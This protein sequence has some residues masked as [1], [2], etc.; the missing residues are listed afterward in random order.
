[1]SITTANLAPELLQTPEYGRLFHYTDSQGFLGI[2]DKKVLWA[3]DCKHLNDRSEY[4]HACELIREIARERGEYETDPNIK[5]QLRHLANFAN[6]IPTPAIGLISFSEH[7]DQ[8]SQW[9][10]YGGSTGYAISFNFEALR[11]KAQS[12]KWLLVRCI[13][14]RDKQRE[15]LRKLIDLAL[16]GPVTSFGNDEFNALFSNSPFRPGINIVDLL[17]QFALLFKN[18]GFSEENEW[19]LISVNEAKHKDIK[20]RPGR[21]GVIPYFEFDLHS[22][23]GCHPIIDGV[24]IGPRQE[25]N[26]AV[27]TAR[28]VLN[29]H[30]IKHFPPPPSN[31]SPES[32]ARPSLIPYRTW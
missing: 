17:P 16:N 2:T 19:R 1:M 6:D 25:Q 9:R 22:A 18:N 20:F 29:K 5:A 3:T 13:H 21:S 15:L 23:T 12:E 4:R 8:L 30:G 7:G 27:E 14:D 28:M 10:A 26:L 24:I 31:V 11:E 32:L